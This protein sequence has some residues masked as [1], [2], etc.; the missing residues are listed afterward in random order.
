MVVRCLDGTYKPGGRY[1][2]VNIDDPSLVP[3]VP[4]S[5]WGA[6]G[7]PALALVNSFA[8]AFLA[9]YN[10]CKYYRELK[11]HTPAR[12]AKCTGT[13]MGLCAV[14]YSISLVAGF[15]TFGANSNAVIIKNYSRDDYLFTAA[16][17]GMGLSLIA[18]YPLM[19]S[20]LRESLVSLGKILSPPERAASFDSLI[21]QD[22]LSVVCVGLVTICAIVLVDA[23]IVVG[24]VG[25]ICGSAIIYIVPSFLHISAVRSGLDVGRHLLELS[26]VGFLGVL[27]I[28]LLV[29]GS[30]NTF[31]VVGV[32]SLV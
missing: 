6:I 9:H 27:G 28:V 19:F 23:G 13:A 24:L 8:I 10:A 7:L 4:A 5:H 21:F 14:L 2:N 16:R 1:Y 32:R 31:S 17:L 29:V 20:G 11:N 30:L 25:A 22:T 3:D 26:F 18:S 15:Q 12:L